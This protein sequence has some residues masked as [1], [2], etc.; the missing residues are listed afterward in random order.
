MCVFS[1][2]LSF[3]QPLVQFPGV[4]RSN[5][6]WARNAELDPGLP[7]RVCCNRELECKVGPGR[8]P[9]GTWTWT[10]SETAKLPTHT[11]HQGCVFVVRFVPTCTGSW[12]VSVK[13]EGD[14][15]GK[16]NPFRARRKYPFGPVRELGCGTLGFEGCLLYLYTCDP[17]TRLPTNLWLTQILQGAWKLAFLL[18]IP[19]IS[20][21]TP[22]GSSLQPEPTQPTLSH[23]PVLTWVSHLGVRLCKKATLPHT[24]QGLGFGAMSEKCVRPRRFWRDCGGLAEP[25]TCAPVCPLQPSQPGAPG[26]PLPRQGLSA[27]SGGALR[28]GQD[29]G[30]RRRCPG[31]REGA[32]EVSLVFTTSTCCVV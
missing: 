6:D 16:D 26:A 8:K 9:P 13:A 3:P 5:Q 2:G 4:S 32:A 10:S 21:W 25:G 28:R 31:R 29:S 12:G 1:P 17:R 7:H 18:G 27:S 23:L 11:V 30:T 14:G 24:T 15:E 22:A 19:S 20:Q